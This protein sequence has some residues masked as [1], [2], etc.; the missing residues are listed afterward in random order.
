MVEITPSD[1]GPVAAMPGL[2][3]DVC[4]RAAQISGQVDC[5]TFP[6]IAR[7]TVWILSVRISTSLA[8]FF[9]PLSNNVWYS[10]RSNF[11]FL[12]A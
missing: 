3:I 8:A 12:A 1:P 7:I 6:S 5:F 9:L 11:N 2:C 10:S 4:S